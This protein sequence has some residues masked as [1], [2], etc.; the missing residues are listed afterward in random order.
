V[1]L[2]LLRSKQLLFPRFSGFTLHRECQASERSDQQTFSASFFLSVNQTSR[3]RA[4][5]SQHRYGTAP[6]PTEVATC[7]APH[8][9]APGDASEG[10]KD[11][12]YA[13]RRHR[14]R[15]QQQLTFQQGTRWAFMEVEVA[16][17]T[18]DSWTAE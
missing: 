16:I 12:R 10:N 7:M 6:S 17:V 13:A 11:R 8:K 4:I 2:S 18:H 14:N 3:V 1:H 9:D 5:S 15:R